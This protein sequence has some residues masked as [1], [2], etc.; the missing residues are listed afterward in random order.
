MT[1]HFA[2]NDVCC[3]ALELSKSTWVC[4]FAPP[5]S[6]RASVHKMRAGDVDR[7][8]GIL[9]TG[10]ARAM[11]DVSRSLEIVLCYEVGYDGFWLARLLIGRGI[12]TVVFD[13]ASFL[14][15]RRGRLAK[16]DRLDAEEMTR[17]LR[18]WLSGDHAI[19][20]AVRIPT[21]EEEDAKRI[22][23]ERKNLVEE[24]TRI[25]G[26]I[27]GLLALHGIWLNSKR[28]NKRLQGLLDTMMTGDGRRLPPFLRRDIERMI[29][30]YE[31]ICGQIADAEA[32]R[33]LTLTDETSSFPHRDK[34]QRLAMLGAV[35]ETTATVLV[36]EVFHRTF[37]TRRHLASFIGFAPS[38]YASGEVSRDRGINKAG[39]KLARQTLVELAWFWLRYQP[40]SKLSLWWHE[41]FG[42]MGMRGRK[43]GIVAL[44]RKLAIALWRFVEQGVVPEG[45][46]L[47][48]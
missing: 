48:A 16:T 3:V 39:T 31:F 37:Q 23:R 26:R 17:I 28:I 41:R 25:V 44:A 13:P 8:L 40:N 5:E 14:K 46:T 18:T 6:G 15:P 1:T 22:E 34:V 47:K 24:R 42:G 12:R 10:R 29:R 33:K 36:A 27:K 45:A 30:H 35:G 9:E 43:V 4:A 21:V 11:R 20:T 19:A 7:L 2:A 38:P 32:D